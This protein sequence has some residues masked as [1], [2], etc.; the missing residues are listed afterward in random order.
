MKTLVLPFALLMTLGNSV[1]RPLLDAH[2][3][4]AV[5][6][7][8]LEGVTSLPTPYQIAAWKATATATDYIPPAAPR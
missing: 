7:K 6:T 1:G 4:N 2:R 3:T 8:K 5:E